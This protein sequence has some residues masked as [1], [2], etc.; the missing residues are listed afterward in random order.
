MAEEI[1]QIVLLEFT[2]SEGRAWT[3]GAT[4]TRLRLKGEG[5]EPHGRKQLR[6]DDGMKLSGFKV[7]V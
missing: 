1:G 6:E 5:A 3:A 2:D 7:A 4:I